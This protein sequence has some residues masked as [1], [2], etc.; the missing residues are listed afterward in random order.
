MN[1][2][3]LGKIPSSDMFA[4]RKMQIALPVAELAKC[5]NCN[6]YFRSPRPNKKELDK[7]YEFG[8][9]NNW[10]YNLS[11]RKDWLIAIKWAEKQKRLGSILDV[12]CFDGG[13]LRN[14]KG[15]ADLYG[16]EINPAASIKAELNG[17]TIIGK[18]I[19]DIDSVSLK[20]D[21]ITAFDMI[22]HV[23]S[24]FE[25][26]SSLVRVMKDDGI[27]IV[28][29]GNSSALTWKLMG[30][31]YWYCVIPEHI[32]F[33]NVKWCQFVAEKLNLNIVYSKTFSHA[34]VNRF[35]KMPVDILKNIIYFISPRFFTILRKTAAS[36]LRKKLIDDPYNCPPY[37]FTSKDHIFIVF[38][39]K[40]CK[41]AK[42]L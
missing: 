3:Y 20:F 22:E 39:K 29:S 36:L 40:I 19:S 26:I 24:P 27:L 6:F 2:V 17:I 7:L 18:Q 41:N 15:R 33:I 5:N 28:S 13:F 10:Q 11:D 37:W 30:S 35:S 21:A 42:L 8:N 9:I 31:R 32:S 16:I 23:F 4:G 34:G 38:R 25:F 12:G 14:L 1:I